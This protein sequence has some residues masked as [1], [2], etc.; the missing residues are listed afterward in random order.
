MSSEN[1]PLFQQNAAPPD[2]CQG[3]LGRLQGLCCS[4]TMQVQ[5]GAYLQVRS[6]P[7]VFCLHLAQQSLQVCAQL[8]LQLWFCDILQGSLQSGPQ[9]VDVSLRYQG[10]SV[11]ALKMAAFPCQDSGLSRPASLRFPCSA[12]YLGLS[13]KAQKSCSPQL[14]ILPWAFFTNRI[15]AGGKKSSFGL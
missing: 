3:T 10:A 8:G 11:P 2:S 9:G 15:G 5:P 1:W 7:G 6:V 14:P 4:C 12:C 13:P